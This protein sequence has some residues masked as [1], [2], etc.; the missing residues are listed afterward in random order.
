MKHLATTIVR[1]SIRTI[2]E[3]L[4]GYIERNIQEFYNVQFEIDL[5]IYIRV[6]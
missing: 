2:L 1:E 5:E 3:T 6:Y 4:Y